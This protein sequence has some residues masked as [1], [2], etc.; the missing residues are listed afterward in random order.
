MIAIQTLIKNLDSRQ[1]V[2]A[3]VLAAKHHPQI[4][5]NKRTG[6]TTERAEENHCA[7]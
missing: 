6:K 2:T 1:D 5:K 3:Q 4:R 7:L